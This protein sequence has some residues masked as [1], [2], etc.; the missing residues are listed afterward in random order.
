MCGRQR[1]ADFWVGIE[2]TTCRLQSHA[3]AP[4]PG[5]NKNT[6]ITTLKGLAL[7]D[8]L[9]ML[10]NGQSL[11]KLFSLTILSRSNDVWMNM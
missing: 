6:L 10:N 4:V 11:L 7:T 5:L 3:C 2:P 1:E 9:W 8:G